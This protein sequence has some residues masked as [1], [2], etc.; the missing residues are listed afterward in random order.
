MSFSRNKIHPTNQ[1]LISSR[2]RICLRTIRQNQTAS[3]SIANDQSS[4][5]RQNRHLR[6]LC[7]KSDEDVYQQLRANRD[8]LCLSGKLPSNSPLSAADTPAFVPKDRLSGHRRAEA[9]PSF[10]RLRPAMTKTTIGGHSCTRDAIT[11]AAARSPESR[12]P[13]AVEKKFGEVASPAKNSRPSTG[14]ASTARIPAWP[15]SAW[16]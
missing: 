5:F 7:S 12:A 15:G 14:A 1:L 11:S 16:E 9:T 10:G 4:I 13:C 2:G 6:S 8:M 3:R